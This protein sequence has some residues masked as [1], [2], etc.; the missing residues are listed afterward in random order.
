MVHGVGAHAPKGKKNL[1]F[2]MSPVVPPLCV[3]EDDTQV[4]LPRPPEQD[5]SGSFDCAAN[6]WETNVVLREMLVLCPYCVVD[7]VLPLG[8][9]FRH[10]VK[11]A[12]L[13]KTKETTS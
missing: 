6:E 1:T 3:G 5:P 8:Q 12:I 7:R 11:R 9:F 13:K 2:G 4:G 10:F